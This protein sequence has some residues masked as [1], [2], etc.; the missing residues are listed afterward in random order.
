IE[1]VCTIEKDGCAVSRLSFG[2]HTGTHVDAPS[3][4][5]KNGL[6]VDSLNLENLMGWAVVLDFSLRKG[7]LKDSI[8]DKAYSDLK[9]AESVSILLLKTK[10]SF[11]WENDSRVSGLQAGESNKGIE[12]EE[13]PENSVYLDSGAAD[14]IVRKGFKTVG[15]DSFSVDSLSS[16]NL[17]AHYTLLSNNV[18]IVECLD[19]SLADA[20]IYFFLCL[21]LKIEGCDGAPARALLISKD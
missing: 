5:L 12:L 1:S 11:H 8:L 16:E 2:S 20:G 7:A 15:I 17:P 13:P 6:S 3:H 4:V 10:S 9:I 19:L 14:W 21:P 18:N